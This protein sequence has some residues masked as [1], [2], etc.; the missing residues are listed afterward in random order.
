MP[1]LPH[2]APESWE[3]ARELTF[4]NS[5]YFSDKWVECDQNI[6]DQFFAR[7]WLNMKFCLIRINQVIAQSAHFL[8][9]I[10][11]G[12]NDHLGLHIFSWLEN[13]GKAPLKIK[14]FWEFVNETFIFSY[15]NWCKKKKNSSFDLKHNHQKDIT[16][17]DTHDVGELNTR[18][19]DDIKKVNDSIGEKAGLV[20]QW[21]LK[22]VLWNLIKY[23]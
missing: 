11:H 17:F 4:K 14:I 7:K 23:R 3:I 16:Y 6:C 19:F 15:L 9:S 1:T 2:R 5:C 8:C 12:K 21:R 13:S 10:G 22:I 18:M 20:T